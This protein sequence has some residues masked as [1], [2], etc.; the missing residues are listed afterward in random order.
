MSP[1]TIYKSPFPSCRFSRSSTPSC[2]DSC[3]P[4]SFRVC[5]PPNAAP[6]PLFLLPGIILYFAAAVYAHLAPRAKILFMMGCAGAELPAV[7]YGTGGWLT[8]CGQGARARKV[9][10]CQY[11]T[12]RYVIIIANVCVSMCCTT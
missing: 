7:V 12:V 9:A 11:K 5:H 3:L 4:G 8:G 2:P 10:H 1:T 6:P